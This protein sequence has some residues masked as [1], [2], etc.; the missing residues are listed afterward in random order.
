MDLSQ[1]KLVTGTTKERK[2]LNPPTLFCNLRTKFGVSKLTILESELTILERRFQLTATNKLRE[3]QI[4]D[5]RNR[6]NR[7]NRVVTAMVQL[8]S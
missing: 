4:N 6:R 2:T 5:Y 1:D 3:I 7:D 8:K